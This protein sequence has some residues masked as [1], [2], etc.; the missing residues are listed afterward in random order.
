MIAEF[1]RY[2]SSKFRILVGALQLLGGVGLVLGF[3]SPFLGL[4]SA[5]GLAVLMLFAFAIRL[6]IQDGFFQTIPSIGYTALNVYLCREFA[7]VME[8]S[9]P[10]IV[11]WL[12]T[13]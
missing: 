11:Q 6:R 1:E 10:T 5:V 7:L 4:F 8:P 3:W 13:V 2:Q 12:W 9:G